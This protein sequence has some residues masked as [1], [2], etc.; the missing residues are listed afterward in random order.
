[1]PAA[2]AGEA[3]FFDLVELS[4]ATRLCDWMFS[5]FEPLARGRVAEVGAGIGTF[6]ARLLPEADELLLI[7]PAARG[8]DELK[9]RFASEPRVTI[10]Q[11]T[12]PGC[13]P[14]AEGGF[15]LVLSQNVLEH[16]ADDAA[17][18]REMGSAVA[19]GG[20]L[21][22]LVPA[23]PRLYGSLDRAYGHHRRYT[24]RRLRALVED[25]GLAVSA[26]YSFNLLGVA[27]WLVKRYQ[28]EPR[29][30]PRSLRAYEA[31]V[32]FWRPLE[33]RVRPPAGLSLVVKAVKQR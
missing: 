11:D 25:A 29:L 16:I 1:V 19:P 21:C 2:D 17:A 27:G 26:L 7:E 12:V 30:D 24:R 33:E 10:S 6:S 9:R 13:P 28:R 20:S 18:V 31:L 22:L 3:E 5:Q 15:D 14:L 8:A 32:R 4:K 23:H